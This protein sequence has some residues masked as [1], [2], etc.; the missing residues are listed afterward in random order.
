MAS[1]K[2]RT[3]EQVV[4]KLSQADRMLAEGKEGS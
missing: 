2:R 4:R 1:R 3:P